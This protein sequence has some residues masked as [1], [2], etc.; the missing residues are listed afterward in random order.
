MFYDY[1]PGINCQYAINGPKCNRG[2]E[3]SEFRNQ[4]QIQEKHGGNLKESEG[5]YKNR[6]FNR[7]N[8]GNG[9][10]GRYQKGNHGCGQ[11][12]KDGNC[13]E[14]FFSKQNKDKG[15]G[16]KY[17]NDNRDD[18]SARCQGGL[19]KIFPLF[20]LLSERGKARCQDGGK[21]GCQNHY[22]ACK[23]RGNR[24]KTRSSC[25]H[26]CREHSN[27]QSSGDS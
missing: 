3:N 14:I 13:L 27:I 24:I 16:N 5:S 15:L 26:H 17:P 7:I 6:L 11:R 18:Y 8:Y 22:K 1:S 21:T 4:N 12:L 9:W 25:P 2:S 19:N 10:N 20:L 23:P